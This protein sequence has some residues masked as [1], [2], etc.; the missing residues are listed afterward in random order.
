[1][2][3]LLAFIVGAHMLVSILKW[4]FRLPIKSIG[5]GYTRYLYVVVHE[6]SHLVV[7]LLVGC[8]VYDLV[9]KETAT[10]AGMYVTKYKSPFKILWINL[11][12]S[13]M[14]IAGPLLPP[15]VFYGLAYGI[16]HD[17][18]TWI[19]VVVGVCLL[20]IFIYSSQRFY[21]IAVGLL[22]YGIGQL[23]NITILDYM[24]I[25]FLLWGMIGM[26]DEVFAI[27]GFDNKGSDMAKFTESLVRVSNP[28]ITRALYVFLQLL[29]AY[30]VYAIIV[31]L[32]ANGF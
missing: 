8:G 2:G 29:Y 11:G 12:E 15:V 7:G 23:T 21:F 26:V 18:Y 17:H 1:M 22:V 32:L 4:V 31:L 30:T 14:T 27:T 9:L 16:V 19:M 5:M 10:G 28:V 13:L 25:V 24:L 20:L 3:L 6:L